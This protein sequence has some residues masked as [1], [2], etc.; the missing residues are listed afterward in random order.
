MDL[1][2]TDE[3]EMLREMVRGVCAEHA[4]SDVVR[5]ME[6]DPRGIPGDFWKQLAELGL[7]GLTIPEEYGGAG[8][9]IL[10]ATVVYEELGRALA[11]SPHFVSSILGAGALLRG[12]SEEQRREWLPRIARGEAILTPAWLEPQG[13]YGPRGVQMRAKRDGRGQDAGYRLNGCKM[14]V[15]FASAA[16][17]LLTL[18]RTGEGERNIDLL[19]VDPGAA[20]VELQQRRS[21]AADTQYRV[22]FHDVAVPR[23]A[24]VGAAH[25]P[26]G[27]GWQTWNQVMHDAIILAAAQAMGGAAR[28]LEITCEYAKEREQFGKP[29]AAFQAISHYLAD[30]ATTIAGGTTLVYEAAWARANGRPVD[31][32]AP[33]AKLFACQTYRDVTA[34]CVQVWGGVGFTVEYDIQL[35]FRRAKQ[36]QL[37]WWDTR[38]LE[39]RVA[40]SVLDEAPAPTA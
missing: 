24:R 10:E 12:G 19:L 4:G 2:F 29:L 18:V 32:L 28:A 21:L 14:H 23:S 31:R 40:C 7:L 35:Y 22:D 30:A 11:P 39:E 26:C 27:W 9:S 33:M 6:D 36:L 16:T 3:Q 13:G 5:A 25:S 17:R 34:K 1:D 8:Q 38:Y 20:G 15:A 37:S